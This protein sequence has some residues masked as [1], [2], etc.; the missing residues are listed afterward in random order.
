M[1]GESYRNHNPFFEST[2]Y[3][4]KEIMA[5][6]PH[7]FEVDNKKCRWERRIL[8]IGDGMTPAAGKEPS[9]IACRSYGTDVKIVVAV[10]SYSH[11]VPKQDY[12]ELGDE[13]WEDQLKVLVSEDEKDI[14]KDRNLLSAW[15][16][17][18]HE[19][20]EQKLV[21]F[22]EQEPMDCKDI[23]GGVQ[24]L[25]DEMSSLMTSYWGDSGSSF[26]QTSVESC[27]MM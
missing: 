12:E 7:R 26:R 5:A 3:K 21:T 13:N 14:K 1:G 11:Q 22:K 16:D 17:K 20:I 25:C 4:L 27:S 15:L 23:E 18:F 6:R 9:R 2:T 19:V 10:E 24:L 8:T